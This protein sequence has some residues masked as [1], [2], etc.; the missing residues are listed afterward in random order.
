MV[1]SVQASYVDM[2]QRPNL[3]IETSGPQ[4]S[5]KAQDM[6]AITMS[7]ATKPFQ[8]QLH[9][10]QNS[11]SMP[12]QHRNTLQQ[13]V[14]AAYA[15]YLRQN[16]S[17]PHPKHPHRQQHVRNE[18]N[19][20]MPEFR[21]RLGH[22]THQYLRPPHTTFGDTFPPMPNIPPP[23]VVHQGLE[24]LN[25]Q[26]RRVVA[27]EGEAAN[28]AGKVAAL[29]QE[30]DQL[31]QLKGRMVTLETQKDRL[32]LEVV[33]LRQ[34]L[35]AM[36]SRGRQCR[37]SSPSPAPGRPTIVITDAVIETPGPELRSP[38]PHAESQACASHERNPNIESRDSQ[39]LLD[40][41]Q[42]RHRA[43]KRRQR[44]TPLGTERYNL[45]SRKGRL[46]EKQGGPL[47]PLQAA[48]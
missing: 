31:Q 9:Q 25:E 37:S 44:A 33:L 39:A 47:R 20:G 38:S 3:R 17:Q 2:K 11:A 13:N 7:S 23:T 18:H 40:G 36:M 28:L 6:G 22:Q 5:A 15:T 10:T 34:D 24:Q 42:I 41:M 1:V 16:P 48:P 35:S 14:P 29:E 45:R 43:A 46:D 8:A 4:T 32:Q 21:P 12:T 26:G 19:V 27:L 30:G